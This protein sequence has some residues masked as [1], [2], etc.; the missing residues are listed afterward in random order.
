MQIYY[1]KTSAKSDTGVQELFKKVA[2][3]MINEAEI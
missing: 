3:M 1:S 2:A